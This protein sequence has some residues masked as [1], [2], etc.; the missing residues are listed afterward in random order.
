MKDKKATITV[1]PG[2]I[3]AANDAWANRTGVKEINPLEELIVSATQLDTSGSFLQ[4]IQEAVKEVIDQREGE[5]S[6]L[7]WEHLD[8]Q[9]VLTLQ[10]LIV[11]RHQAQENGFAI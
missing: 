2:S 10:A 6:N 8:H 11:L 4:G 3:K 5:T 9:E 1:G 7:S